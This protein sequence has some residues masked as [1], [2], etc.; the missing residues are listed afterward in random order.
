MICKK[1]YFTIGLAALFIVLT[2]FVLSLVLIQGMFVPKTYLEPW[3]P[4]YY[5]TFEDPRLQVIAHG[6]LAP[7]AHNMQSWRI[8]LNNTDP[9]KFTLYLDESRLLPETDPMHRQSII[10]Q[11]TFLE[12]VSTSAQKLGYKAELSLWPYGEISINPSQDEIHKTPVAVVSLMPGERENPPRYDAIFNRAT[13]RVNYLEKPLTSDQIQRITALNNYDGIEVFLI[14]DSDDLNDLKN[15]TIEGVNIESNQYD[16]MNETNIIFRYSEYQK[17][18]FR[19]GVDITSLGLAPGP[20]RFLIE[21]LGSLFPSSPLESG[22]F[23]RESATATIRNTP[24]YLMIVSDA[25]DRATQVKVG[26]LYARIQ[27]EGTI[28]GLSMQ[29]TMQI[30]QEYPEMSSLYDIVHKRFVQNG[31]TVQMLVRIG[32]A[33]RTMEHSMRKDVMELISAS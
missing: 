29:P 14:T 31:Q 24:V 6:L 33:E 17:N 21:S 19:F 7:N 11:G 20:I 1:K 18:R 13:A 10:S 28:L 3:D 15:L 8:V 27:L 23:W 12:L 22:T 4:Q 26:M 32:E 9:T 2:L 5:T 25:N 30:T 16:Q